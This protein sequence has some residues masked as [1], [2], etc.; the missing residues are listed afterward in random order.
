[1]CMCKLLPGMLLT[2]KFTD[3]AL[4]VSPLVPARLKKLVAVASDRGNTVF[5][6]L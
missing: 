6:S 3:A 2:L 1:M 4:E 5:G